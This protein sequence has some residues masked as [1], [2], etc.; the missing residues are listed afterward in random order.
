M[1]DSYNELAFYTLNL[2]DDCFIHQY[3]VDAHTAQNATVNT[4]PISL[5]F[6]LVG[7]YLNVEKKYTG[8]QV[9]RFHTLMSEHKIVWPVYDLPQSRGHVNAEM[10]LAAAAGDAIKDMIQ[11]WCISV[12]Q[13][14]EAHQIQVKQIVTYYLDIEMNLKKM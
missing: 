12:W 8:K 13:T 10:V 1:F 3:I 4:K 14:F 9:Q 2:E 6:A 7:L 5:N 11:Q